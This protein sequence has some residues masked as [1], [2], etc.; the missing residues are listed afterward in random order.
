MTN[1]SEGNLIKIKNEA[2]ATK[3]KILLEAQGQAEAVKL[4]AESQ[5]N[6]LRMISAELNKPGGQEAARLAL[7]REYVDMYGEM[8]KQSNTILFNER[9]ADVSALLTQ[10]MTAMQAA[11]KATNEAAPP[12]PTA[13]IEA[14]PSSSETK[15]KAK[16]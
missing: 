4:M 8:G 15:E 6:A 1:E 12:A 10:A 9:P 16:E 3:T 2:D 14:G 13:A 5:A 7:A 11:P